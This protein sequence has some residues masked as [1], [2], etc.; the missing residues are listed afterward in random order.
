MIILEREFSSQ[1]LLAVFATMLFAM[2]EINLDLSYPI[3]SLSIIKRKW[4]QG[5]I[6]SETH[7]CH[8][9]PN[10]QINII[11]AMIFQ[12]TCWCCSSYAISQLFKGRMFDPHG[13]LYLYYLENSSYLYKKW[14]QW[15][16]N[17]HPSCSSSNCTTTL[18][19]NIVFFFKLFNVFHKYL[20]PP[21]KKLKIRH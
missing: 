19:Y 21:R 4:S 10:F 20:A 9:T 16:L 12:L 13:T 2:I 8:C 5:R 3:I 18:V 11:L 14:S 15:D 7:E 1:F 6:S 17:Q